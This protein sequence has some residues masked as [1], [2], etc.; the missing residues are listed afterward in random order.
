M[1]NS[2]IQKLNEPTE[3]FE[4]FYKSYVSDVQNMA[5]ESEIW[6]LHVYNHITIY[7][8]PRLIQSAYE[9][10]EGNEKKTRTTS[11]K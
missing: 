6:R 9:G 10:I 7:S 2:I 5:L 8:I 11:K 3:P 4:D 1:L